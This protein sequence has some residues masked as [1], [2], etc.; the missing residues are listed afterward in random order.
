[1]IEERDAAPAPETRLSL[2]RGRF[3][4]PTLAIVLIITLL[5]FEA[6]AVG[7]VMP[8]VVGELGGLQLYAWGFSAFLISS[9][10][11]NVAAGAWSDRSGPTMPMVVAL[12]AF[13]TGLVI[14]GCAPAMWAFIV[15]R[16]AQGLGAGGAV[17][18]IYVVI[19]RTYPEQM[20]RRVFAALAAAW[21]IPSLVGPALAGFVAQHLHWRWV[22]LG[23]V[24]LVVPASVLL[25][26]ALRGPARPGDGRSSA[27]P[28]DGQGQGTAETRSTVTGRLLAAVAVAAGAVVL[29]YAIDHVS[30]RSPGAGPLGVLALLA[31]VGLAG[32]LSGLPRLFPAGALRLRRGLPT[33]VVMRGL[34]SAAFFGAEALIPLALTSQHGFSPMAAGAV[35]TVGALGWSA[36]SWFQSRSGWSHVVLVRSGSVLVLAGGVAATVALRFSGW[37]AAPA[38]LVAGAGMGLALANLSVLTL[39]LSPPDEQGTNSAALQISDTVGSALGVG[40]AGAL[41]V[42]FGAGR[43]ST[44]LVAAGLSTVAIALVAV[45]AGPRLRHAKR[46]QQNREVRENREDTVVLNPQGD[47]ATGH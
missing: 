16:V 6:M 34:L 43:L 23:L 38:W 4:T 14:S 33:V 27:R 7:T 1:M 11:A 3:R 41:A 26:P 31:A 44:G 18:L 42:G 37:L 24:P 39:N 17:V 22:F 13:V 45:G 21:V 2:L 19:A 29:L 36:A 9:L 8:V 35:L 30:G 32:L 40:V 10:L 20:R 28:G 15:G 25:L 12:C 46:E 5:A 47:P